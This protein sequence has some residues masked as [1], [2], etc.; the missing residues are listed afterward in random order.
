MTANGPDP[1]PARGAAPGPLASEALDLSRRLAEL[2][3]R[4]HGAMADFLVAL[5]DFDRRRLWAPLGYASLFHYLHRG[6]GLSKGSAFYR[7][8]AAG[9]VRRFPEVVE[10]LRDGRLCI[11]G[12]VEL[13]KVMDEGNRAEVLPRFFHRS[14]REA[15]AVAVEIRP[16]SVVPWR[17]VVSR[18]ES[19]RDDAPPASDRPGPPVP[20]A[21]AALPAGPRGPVGPSRSGGLPQPADF[22]A[23]TDP[24][25][26]AEPRSTHPGG[27]KSR[28]DEAV[29]LT[30][31]LRRLHVT[32]SHRFLEK[33][34]AARDALSHSHP[35]AATE[36]VL[37]VGLDLLLERHA[38]RRGLGA[39]RGARG[40]RGGP[41]RPAA[42]R[43]PAAA[44]DTAPRQ[45]GA[46]RSPARHVPAEVR[47]AV[48]ER[49]GGRCQWPL[50]EGVGAGPGSG[51]AGSGGD[52][53]QRARR[54]L[55]VCGS[56]VRVELDHV[57]PVS[58]GGLS[59]VENCRLLCRF[60]ND[61]AA[62]LELGDE[63]MDAVLRQAPVR[64]RARGRGSHPRGPSGPRAGGGR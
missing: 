40:A 13:A 41:G 28:A 42:D 50:A 1:V 53:G 38:R 61:L 60:H 45:R 6:L 47:R 35:G 30:A 20:R 5:A 15:R 46:A 4:E 29:P 56:T 16:A 39:R 58:R 51:A 27:G 37:E 21:R 49:D 63:W 24:V 11:T 26:P 55:A 44:R 19:G 9:L 23:S 57:V 17:A 52:G 22:L 7:K 18:V 64:R 33:L 2:L 3:R 14:R 36:Q 43:G 12:V 54:E 10:P 48:W 25:Q 31:E 59:T 32:V 8:T 62:R 34:D